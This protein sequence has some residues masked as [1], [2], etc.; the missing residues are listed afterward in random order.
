MSL[1]FV[2]PVLKITKNTRPVAATDT[3]VATGRE[4]LPIFDR[5]PQ[6]AAR[7]RAPS[8][9]DRVRVSQHVRRFPE[10]T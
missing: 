1:R 3:V 10:A 2:R 9:C 6:R 8:V 7:E 4:L 5:W